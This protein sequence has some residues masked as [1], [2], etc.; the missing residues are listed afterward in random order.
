MKKYVIAALSAL[1]LAGCTQGLKTA[2]KNPMA[3]ETWVCVTNYY[4]FYD[5]GVRTND[6]IQFDKDGVYT[7]K[8][9]IVLPIIEKPLFVYH[10]DSFGKWEYKNNELT[11]FPA[12]VDTKPA[13]S[14]ETLQKLK[15]KKKLREIEKAFNNTFEQN[16]APM[17]FKIIK[18]EDD[19]IMQE[20]KLGKSTY[21]PFCMKGETLSKKVKAGEIKLNPNY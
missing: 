17:T 2:D 4:D 13:H 19:T 16:T 15:Q 10:Q 5:I 1:T 8:G 21:Y 14:K 7:A 20:Q 3:G 9:I 11:L 6:I 12:H 18:Q